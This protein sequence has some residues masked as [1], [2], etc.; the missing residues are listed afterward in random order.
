M[1]YDEFKASLANDVAPVELSPYLRA[2]WED[3]RGNW[4]QAH[5]LV[6]AEMDTEAAW[7]HAY[8][9][10]KEGDLANADYWYHRCEMPVCDQSLE[11]EWERIARA[12]LD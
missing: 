7:I 12:L 9:H 1:T 6:Q 5:E 10:R 2:L 3:A 4:A 8:L 11:L